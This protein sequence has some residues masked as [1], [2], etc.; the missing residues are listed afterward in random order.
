[1]AGAGCLCTW[2]RGG[3]SRSEDSDRSTRTPI[4]ES[5]VL[6]EQ[7]SP[8]GRVYRRGFFR[9]AYPDD[10]LAAAELVACSQSDIATG[11]YAS[12]YSNRLKPRI[13]SIATIDLQRIRLDGDL[14]FS[15]RSHLITLDE[16]DVGI[17]VIDS[18]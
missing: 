6:Y 16:L 18:D 3:L 15:C 4:F 5:A 11:S 1:M 17:W 9:V 10:T 12:K 14:I 2:I 8:M 7:Y 13:A